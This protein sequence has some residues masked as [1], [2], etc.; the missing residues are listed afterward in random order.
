MS[1]SDEPAMPGWVKGFAVAGIILAVL[2]VVMLLAGHGPG[3]HLHGSPPPAVTQAG[4][5]R[6]FGTAT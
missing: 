3:R 6:I 5:P 2:I 4:S 1:R